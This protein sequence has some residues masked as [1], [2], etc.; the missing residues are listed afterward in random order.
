MSGVADTVQ[1]LEWVRDI[2]GQRAN[3]DRHLVA[4]L[5]LPRVAQRHRNP[6]SQRTR[7]QLVFL[8]EGAL[9]GTAAKCE[10]DIV[11]GRSCLAANRFD[12]A[13]RNS[14]QGE[15]PLWRNRAIHRGPR[16]REGGR[17]LVFA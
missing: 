10:H 8:G 6:G 4:R 3:C 1:P 11:D 2:G 12:P 7:R 5:F 14:L 15:P 13:Q 9:Q 16:C 17:R